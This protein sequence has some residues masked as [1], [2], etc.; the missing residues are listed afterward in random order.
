[1]TRHLVSAGKLTLGSRQEG[2][3]LLRG[4]SDGS[5][6][7]GCGGGNSGERRAISTERHSRG[8]GGT[9]R[10]FVSGR[11]AQAVR[12]SVRPA[13]KLTMTLDSHT[14]CIE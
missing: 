10:T 13:P 6:T 5:T 8:L 12:V 4:Q 7:E 3:R 11:T 2:P 1:M 9:H 14:V